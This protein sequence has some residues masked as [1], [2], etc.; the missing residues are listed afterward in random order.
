MFETVYGIALQRLKP[1]M[2]KVCK[3]SADSCDAAAGTR[4]PFFTY[5]LALTADGILALLR[6]G[7]KGVVGGVSMTG[8]EIHE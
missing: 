2:M 7:V 3:N 4:Y 1:K 5:S 6:Y 8:D